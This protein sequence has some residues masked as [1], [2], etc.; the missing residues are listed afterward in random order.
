MTMARRRNKVDFDE[1]VP[2]EVI[3]STEHKTVSELTNIIEELETQFKKSVEDYEKKIEDL[4]SRLEMLED[5]FKEVINAI[6]K[7][8]GG[9]P[10]QAKT[11]PVASSSPVSAPKAPSGPTGGPSGGPSGSPAIPKL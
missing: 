8:K 4:T 2:E 10:V 3:E 5:D 9:A 6:Q 7:S 11:N 1:L